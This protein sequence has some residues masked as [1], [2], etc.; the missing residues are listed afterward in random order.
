MDSLVQ[1]DD[2]GNIG[3][4]TYLTETPGIL[5]MLKDLVEGGNKIFFFPC[6]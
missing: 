5:S 6:E 1:S 2:A 4:Q 3:V